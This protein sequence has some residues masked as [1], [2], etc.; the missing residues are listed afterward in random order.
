MLIP[1]AMAQEPTEAEKK[2]FTMGAAYEAYMGR[3]SRL[4][5]PRYLAFVDGKDGQRFLDVGTGT[6]S[7]A[8]TI[9]GMLKSSEVVGVD[10]SAGF[11]GLAKKNAKTQRAQFEVG[12]AQAMRFGDA[13]FDQTLSL[14]VLNFI[15]DHEKAIREM[16]RVTRPRGTVSACVWDYNEGMQSL[17]FFW[18]E[19]VALDPAMEPKD[20]RHMKLT[21][22]GQLGEAW[23]KAG[24]VDVREQPIVVDQGFAS[25]DDYWKP[26]LTGVGPGGAYVVSLSEDKRQELGSR[27]R[28]RFG[29]GAFTLKARVWCVRGLAP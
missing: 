29:D 4:V 21:R 26:F 23:K 18:D 22:Q 7:V 6:G 19:V 12:D 3:W 13:S 16:R 1:P 27:L 25:F 15:P 5:V 28:K 10:P 8:L 20:E 24:L 14:L 11:I 9:E 17:R 2:M